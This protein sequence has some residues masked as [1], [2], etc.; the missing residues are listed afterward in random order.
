M[1][2]Y[3]PPKKESEKLN[4]QYNY[5]AVEKTSPME[6]KTMTRYERLRTDV[7]AVADRYRAEFAAL[8]ATDALPDAVREV[9]RT[10]P[11]QPVP[12]FCLVGIYPFDTAMHWATPTEAAGDLKRLHL[13][14]LLDYARGVQFRREHGDG[15]RGDA[16][17]VEEDRDAAGIERLIPC[18]K[19]IAAL[20]RAYDTAHETIKR[21]ERIEDVMTYENKGGATFLRAQMKPEYRALLCTLVEKIEMID[22]ALR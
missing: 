14:E 8:E 3:S 7:H 13:G 1:I 2:T 22:T 6:A 5:Y 15:H 4:S 18:G 11:G 17:T 16:L 10:I 21:G 20:Q 12:R 19:T 9:A